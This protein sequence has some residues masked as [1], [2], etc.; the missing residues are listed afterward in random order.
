MLVRVDE[1]LELLVVRKLMTNFLTFQTTM[2]PNS[3]LLW[4]W[5]IQILKIYSI[6]IYV[7]FHCHVS[8]RGFKGMSTL[9]VA[10]FF[11]EA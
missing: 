5:N 6:Y 4:Q 1:G 3:K 10:Y 9:F 7:F 8:F 2:H 11:T